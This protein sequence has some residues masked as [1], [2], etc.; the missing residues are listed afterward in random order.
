MERTTL[1]LTVAL[2]AARS[3]AAAPTETFTFG[4]AG[5]V[6][7]YA[8][9]GPPEAVVLFVSG[10]GGFQPRPRCAV[11]RV[12]PWRAWR[13]RKSATRPAAICPRGRRC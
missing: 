3:L 6:A 9:P 10:D 7:I 4:A 8:P 11:S 1:G 5:S 12:S 2:L 13:A